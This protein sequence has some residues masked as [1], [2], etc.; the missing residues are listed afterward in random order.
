[1]TL[2][3]LILAYLRDQAATALPGPG[4]LRAAAVSS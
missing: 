4:T 1:M 2:E 3:E